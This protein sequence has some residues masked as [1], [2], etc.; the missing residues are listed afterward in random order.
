MSLL[1]AKDESFNRSEIV[2]RQFVRMEFLVRL[3]PHIKIY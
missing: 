3:V 2:F 1:A